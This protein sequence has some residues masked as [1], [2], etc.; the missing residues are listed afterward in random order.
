MRKTHTHLKYV[1]ISQVQFVV[2]LSLVFYNKLCFGATFRNLFSIYYQTRVTGHRLVSALCC[3]EVWWRV[4][5]VPGHCLECLTGIRCESYSVLGQIFHEIAALE[6]LPPLK[7]Y[8]GIKNDTN[9]SPHTTHRHT[10]QSGKNLSENH[11]QVKPAREIW[12]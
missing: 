10:L 12:Q 7:A 3:G 9:V 8:L 2:E 1:S 6:A 5:Y 4:I 11:R